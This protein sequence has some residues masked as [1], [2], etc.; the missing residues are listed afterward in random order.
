ME[1]KNKLIQQKVNEEMALMNTFAE[2][3]NNLQKQKDIFSPEEYAKKDAELAEYFAKKFAELK[4]KY[5]D[6]K[7]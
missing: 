4:A 1:D 2:E 3:I 5:K 7:Y 6:I